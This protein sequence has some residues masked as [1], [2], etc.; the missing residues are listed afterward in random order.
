MSPTSTDRLEHPPLF[1]AFPFN[2]A[3]RLMAGGD[4]RATPAQLAAFRRF[5]TIGDPVADDLVAEMRDLPPGEGRRLFNQALDHGIETIDDP[6]PALRAYF[7]AIE[8]V[9]VWV[10]HDRLALGARTMTRTGILGVYGPLPDI[11][12]MG[13]YL[14]SK[15]DKVLVRSGDL[16]AKAPG[17]LI[18]TA[19][20]WVQIST[21][22]GLDRFSDG[23]KSTARVRLTHAHIRAAIHRR[24]DWDY[25]AWDDPVNQIHTVGTLI[26]FSVVFTGGLQMLGFQFSRREREAIFHFWR[27]MGHLL[28]VHPDLLPATEADAWRIT[29]LE[30]LTEFLPDEDSKKLAAAMMEAVPTAHGLRGDGPVSRGL[31]WLLR[32]THGAYSRLALG[33]R[34]ADRLG[35]PDRPVFLGVIGAIAAGN[36]ALETARRITP[37]ATSLAVRLGDASRRDL[38]ERA[39]RTSAPDLSFTREP[40]AP[41]RPEMQPA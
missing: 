25:E 37:G 3:T 27:Y 8:S 41:R 31:G 18:E 24:D 20:W 28:G 34:N 36:F 17:R 16:Y 32:Q 39:S 5:A 12:L 6:P 38:L 21:P 22:G 1:R 11:A 19:T 30:A 23:F 35:L 40:D 26:L 14:S 4:V 33:K 9:P 29:W 13:G 15:P 2:I 7:A 10:D